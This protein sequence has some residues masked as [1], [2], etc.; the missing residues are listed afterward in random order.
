MEQERT[1]YT[2]QRTEDT[3]PLGMVTVAGIGVR[4]QVT[5]GRSVEATLRELGLVPAPYQ[6]VRVN[7]EEVK[8]L[9]VR[10]L[11]PDEVVTIT[12]LVKGG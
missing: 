12:N 9:A 10:R 3:A 7:A 11:A 4:Y 6:T 8:D 1:V 5:P 2:N